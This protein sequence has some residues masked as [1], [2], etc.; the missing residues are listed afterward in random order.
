[1][2]PSETSPKR[3][4]DDLSSL[5]WG[6]I[7]HLI[8]QAKA[9]SARE[10]GDVPIGYRKLNAGRKSRLARHPDFGPLVVAVFR[11]ATESS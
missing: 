7:N 8:G 2:T 1:M 4:L 9:H 11:R 10:N 6:E 5:T 3:S